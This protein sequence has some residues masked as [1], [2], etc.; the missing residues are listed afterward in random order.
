MTW[1]T[2]EIIIGSFEVIFSIPHGVIHGCH[3]FHFPGMEGW[4]FDTR[5]TMGI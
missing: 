3:P 4:V 5:R 1:N 2:E